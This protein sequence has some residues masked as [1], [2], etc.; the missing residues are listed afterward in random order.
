M[1]VGS[2]GVGIKGSM[3]WIG[4]SICRLTVEDQ[5]GDEIG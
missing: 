3:D 4:K 5:E 1:L 2:N